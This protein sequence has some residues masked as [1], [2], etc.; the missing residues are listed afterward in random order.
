[1][2]PHRL[3]IEQQLGSTAT[4]GESR[5]T[6]NQEGTHSNNKPVHSALRD[7]HRDHVPGNLKEQRVPEK[8]AT[9]HVDV[10][11]TCPQLLCVLLLARPQHRPAVSPL[12]PWGSLTLRVLVA[13]PTLAGRSA[14]A[15]SRG[16]EDSRAGGAAVEARARAATVAARAI[17]ATVE[18]QRELSGPVTQ[19]TGASARAPKFGRL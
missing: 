9:G 13:G 2:A 11:T 14:P 6:P 18:L 16:A 5:P 1:M 19:P 3:A 15:S 12:D 17:A 7:G 8:K 10:L 4:S